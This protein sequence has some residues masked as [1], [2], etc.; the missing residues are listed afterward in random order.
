MEPPVNRLGELTSVYSTAPSSSTSRAS[1]AVG[2][3]ASVRNTALPGSVR[4]IKVVSVS[5]GK[6]GL[7]NRASIAVMALASPSPS[8]AISARPENP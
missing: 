7:V 1:T 3:G 5:P 6:T 8:S 2:P 4:Q